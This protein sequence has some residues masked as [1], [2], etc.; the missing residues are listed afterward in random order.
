MRW[1]IAL[2]VTHSSAAARLA[3]RR[4]ATASKVSRHWIGGMRLVA[5]W[6]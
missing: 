3:L 4:R 6:A 1:L 2:T 5:I